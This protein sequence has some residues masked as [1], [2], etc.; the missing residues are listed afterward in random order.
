[1]VYLLK[2]L[3]PS[4]NIM[5][6]KYFDFSKGSSYL[7]RAHGKGGASATILFLSAPPS[8]KSAGGFQRAGKK[9]GGWGEGIFARPLTTP[10][11]GRVSN[12]ILLNFQNVYV[13]RDARI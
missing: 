8:E 4:N 7:L 1:M 10:K 13:G 6:P 3:I 11:A 5:L 2:G 12:P 9:E